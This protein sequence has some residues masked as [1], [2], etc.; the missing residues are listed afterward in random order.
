MIYKKRTTM[1]LQIVVFI[2]AAFCFLYVASQSPNKVTNIVLIGATGDL[3]K[4]YLW[5]GLFNLYLE[6]QTSDHQ[7]KIFGG[8]RVDTRKG[9]ELIKQVL[10]EKLKCENCDDAKEKFKKLV[11][12]QQLK[13]E[14]D[15]VRFCSMIN[16]SSTSVC[17]Q[18]GLSQGVCFTDSYMEE[19]GRLFYLSIPP[20]AYAE[21]STFIDKHCRPALSK[22]WLRVVLEKPFGNDLASA[23]KLATDLRLSLKEEEMYRIDH[24]LGKTVSM[25]ILKFRKDN[26]DTLGQMWDSHG[27]DRVDI[28]MSETVDV[29]GRTLFYNEYGVIRDVM[30]NHLTELLVLIAMDLPNNLKNVTEIH[31]KKLEL[32]K[33]INVISPGN[34]L[35]GQYEGYASHVR[36]DYE[37]KEKTSKK[38]TYAAALLHV[39]NNRWH[40]VN[41]HLVSGKKLKQRASY[42]KVTFKNRK[43]CFE[44]N[45]RCNTDPGVLIFNI[46]HGDIGSS[47]IAV[48]KSLP[49]PNLDWS[50][51][52]VENRM[53]FGQKS[54]DFLV[55]IPPKDADAYSSLIS[56]VFHGDHN[57]FVST[58]SLMVSWE[59]WTPAVQYLDNI[60]PKVYK[61]GDN[62]KELSFMSN[63]IEL[64]YLQSKSLED[65]TGGVSLGVFR[66]APLNLGETFPLVERLTQDIL[67]SAQD[68]ITSRGVFHLGL[69]GG[70]TIPKLFQAL[71]GLRHNFPWQQ[72]HIWVVD[73]R[74]V[75]FED[76]RSNFGKIQEK[77]L[78]FIRVPFMNIHPMPVELVNGV[79]SDEDRGDEIYAASIRR[80]V[81]N[82]QFDFLVQ[83]VGGDGRTAS[84]F[85]HTKSLQESEKYVI[86]SDGGP[87]KISKKRMTLTFPFINKSRRIAVLI[88]GKGKADIMGVLKGGTSDVQSYPITGVKPETGELAWFIDLE[89][90]TN[91]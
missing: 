60:E 2:L 19:S 16:A 53:I 12:Y 50:V 57:L 6:K 65:T 35:V 75:P 37:D 51:R 7:F 79:C 11:V 31:R 34:V 84:L 56:G 47:A 22:T 55:F 71:L 5:Q 39:S 3:A 64:Q 9:E 76:E 58:E 24:Y 62:L 59:K 10:N 15:Y 23:K 20:F 89:A 77:L 83:G 42:V 33:D 86:Y 21:T 69:S 32:L 68:A 8:A 82:S 88:L 49:T 72:T 13:R 61:G 27:I 40:G 41:F 90:F 36:E 30:Q 66:D 28:V 29:K 1:K 52:K 18:D 4:K 14:D 73:E 45:E 70:T 44:V 38:S 54:E 67:Q 48:T 78:K 87:E 17:S 91:S 26:E 85:P 63:G 81:K 25:E 46:G 74:C 43:T 80:H